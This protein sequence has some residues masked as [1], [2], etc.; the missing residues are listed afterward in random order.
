MGGDNDRSRYYIKIGR[1]NIVP[2]YQGVI[3]SER[4]IH[5]WRKSDYPEPVLRNSN[6]NYAR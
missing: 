3:I 4:T 1:V 5:D 6:I 2:F